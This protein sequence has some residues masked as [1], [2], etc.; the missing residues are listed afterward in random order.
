LKQSA[1]DLEKHVNEEADKIDTPRCLFNDVIAKKI[2]DLYIQH[3]GADNVFH[4]TIAKELLAW[5]GASNEV[6][7]HVK[8]QVKK[9]LYNEKTNAPQ[10][11]PKRWTGT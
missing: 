9:C 1:R 3:G 5:L 10:G 4:I 2:H 7:E 6:E 8:L 11:I